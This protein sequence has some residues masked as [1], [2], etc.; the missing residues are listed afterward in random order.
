MTEGV[1][2]GESSHGVVAVGDSWMTGYGLPL[3][4]VSCLSWA[5]WLA[6]ALSTCITPHGVNGARAVQV[7]RDQ[8][9]LLAG[10]RYRLGAAWFGANDVAHLDAATFEADV[11]EVCTRLRASAD[12][13][14]IGTLPTAMRVPDRGW[15]ATEDAVRTANDAIRQAAVQ[16]DAVVVE[17]EDALNNRWSMAPDRQHPTSLGQLEAASMAALAL[18]SLPLRRVLPDPNAFAVSTAHRRLYDVAPPQRVRARYVGLMQRRRDRQ[19]RPG[20]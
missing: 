7:A 2:V 20:R 17:L 15:R 16:A 4:G 14:A 19:H 9:P 5:G 8:L 13:V 6:W 11:R 1:G 3:G 18:S 12:V 10:H